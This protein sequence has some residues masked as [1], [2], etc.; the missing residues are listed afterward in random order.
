MTGAER[1]LA[2]LEHFGIGH[3]F[4]VPGVE[5][6]PVT[7]AAQRG[8]A[9]RPV[10]VAHEQACAFA[11]FGLARLTGR[12]GVCLVVPGPGA[13]NL[14]TGL[15]AAQ[16][17]RVPL[18]AVTTALPADQRGTAAPHDCD[19][20]AVLA[21]L[22]KARLEPGP[23]EDVGAAM[24]E[25][26]RL[27]LAAPRGPV[28]LMVTAGQLAAEAT[29]GPLPGPTP[30]LP[31]TPA[32]EAALDRIA[33]RLQAAGRPLI[34]AGQ[35]VTDAGAEGLVVALA[36][37]LQAAVF[38]DEAARGLV[39][40]RHPLALGTASH[41][42]I[43]PVLAGCDAGLALGARFSGWSTRN[44]ALPFPRPLMRIDA[45]GPVAFLE[46]EPPVTADLRLCLEAL[47]A[48]LG[49]PRFAGPQAAAIAA[50][51][52]E[53]AG[54]VAALLAGH[55]EA[56]GVHPL[57]ALRAIRAVLPDDAVIAVDGSATGTWAAEEVLAVHRPHGF[58][59]P[60]VLKELGSALMVGMGAAL[61][62]PRPVV[63]VQGDGGLLFQ[64]GELATLVRERI[65]LVVVVFADG[66]Y[67]A[68]RLLLEHL[69]RSDPD[70]CRLH[71]PDF[72]ALAA[73]FG[74]PGA[75]CTT[76]GAL[77]AALRQALDRGGPALLSVAID[78]AP[79]PHRLDLAFRS[80]TKR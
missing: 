53:A 49:P 40:E 79:V 71:N 16:A 6:L 2:A 33:A 41:R 58:L 27:A 77:E 35:G 64:A 80:L 3:L 65:P 26:L 1:L 50:A 48:R 28:Q 56:A 42:A 19:I 4:H 38:T 73:A 69:F 60:E 51:R 13:T 55:D 62:G 74:L 67:N 61:A 68:D 52:A 11:A 45:G 66:H 54:T 76:A 72:A 29:G 9:V 5:T 17:D 22:V 44:G 37:R 70:G 63:A 14:A 36:E 47:L 23:G 8:G 43:E 12:P 31:L 39:D 30:P 20:A 15:A 32:D 18:V 24:A 46:A 78:R 57:E 25:A 75:H 59:T 7:L 10:M 34:Y 21:P